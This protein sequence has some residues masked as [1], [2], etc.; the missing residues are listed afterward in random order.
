MVEGFESELEQ[1]CDALCRNVTTTLQD[2]QVQFCNKRLAVEFDFAILFSLVLFASDVPDIGLTCSGTRPADGL[3]ISFLACAFPA[4]WSTFE[5]S[6]ISRLQSVQVQRT[7]L[8]SADI[9]TASRSLA[10][11]CVGSIVL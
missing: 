1:E 6:C 10:F 4:R 11:V 8:G 3:D 9:V 5:I 2:R 7:V